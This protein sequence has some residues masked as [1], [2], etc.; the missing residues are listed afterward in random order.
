MVLAFKVDKASK[1]F[2]DEFLPT[3]HF[4]CENITQSFV[5]DGR[6]I[7]KLSDVHY[8]VLDTGNVMRVSASWR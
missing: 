6:L 8:I 3:V 7:T 5:Y 2:N 4:I 1:I